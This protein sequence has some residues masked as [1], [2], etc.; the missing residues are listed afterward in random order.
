MAPNRQQR[1]AFHLLSWL[2]CQE[3]REGPRWAPARTQHRTWVST[4]E[5]MAEAQKGAGQE[6]RGGVLIWASL[7]QQ[8][9]DRLAQPRCPW[10]VHPGAGVCVGWRPRRRGPAGPGQGYFAWG[11][12]LRWLPTPGWGSNRG[13]PILGSGGPAPGWCPCFPIAASAA[14]PFQAGRGWPPTR[15]LNAGPLQAAPPAP[16]PRQALLLGGS[17]CGL[18]RDTCPENATLALT[19]SPADSPSAAPGPA[20]P[21]PTVTQGPGVLAAL[22][23][24]C[25]C[26][27]GR[28][29]RAGQP[30]SRPGG[31]AAQQLPRPASLQL[32]R[33]LPGAR[34]PAGGVPGSQGGWTGPPHPEPLSA[35]EPGT[36]CRTDTSP[37]AG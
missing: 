30:A 17:T 35:G 20:P 27:G 24:G 29:T 12:S 34:G 4:A 5:R 23:C 3:S 33:H 19:S 31:V 37:G 28:R 8:C 18:L 13:L 15:H 21:F 14:R 26:S 7:S 36:P 32:A 6:T 11:S 2:N 9:G 1:R 16:P 22:S 10:R 25:W